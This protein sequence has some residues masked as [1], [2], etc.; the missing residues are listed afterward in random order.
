MLLGW[1]SGLGSR[2]AI[3]LVPAGHSVCSQVWLT[4]HHS[5]AGC[6]PVNQGVLIPWGSLRVRCTEKDSGLAVVLHT[7]CRVAGQEALNLGSGTPS[8]AVTGRY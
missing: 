2:E 3:C 5:L 1:T 8:D 7:E 4:V 6:C